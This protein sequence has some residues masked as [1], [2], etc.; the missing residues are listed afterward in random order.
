MRHPETA[1]LA[2]AAFEASGCD[3]H[4]RFIALFGEGVIGLRTFR[5]WLKGEQPAAPIARLL[6]REF[7]GGWRPTL[8]PDGLFEIG[9]KIMF[10]CKSCGASTELSCDVEEF[11]PDMA[12]CG[13][14]PRCLP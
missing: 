6:L 9:G 5:G 11:D 10:E 3:T 1:R 7:V 12:Y 13:G 4:P 2:T 14:S 8:L